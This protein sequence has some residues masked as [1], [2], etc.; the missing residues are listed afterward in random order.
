MI[1]YIISLSS[2]PSLPDTLSGA[3]KKGF[4]SRSENAALRTRLISIQY[5]FIDQKEIQCQI[6]LSHTLFNKRHLFSREIY[7]GKR[8]IILDNSER[9]VFP[10]TSIRNNN[11]GALLVPQIPPL[12]NSFLRMKMLKRLIGQPGQGG[13]IRCFKFLFG[14]VV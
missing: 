14:H 3:K 4:S 5:Y 7:P 10:S 2:P 8:T 1:S 11:F 12:T 9:H 13:R 6:T